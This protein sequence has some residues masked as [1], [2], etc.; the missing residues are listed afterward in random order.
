MCRQYLDLDITL[1]EE[2]V[3]RVTQTVLQHLNRSA[4]ELRRLFLIEDLIDSIKVSSLGQPLLQFFQRV[5]FTANIKSA[6]MH[7]FSSL[8]SFFVF[9]FC[10]M[11]Q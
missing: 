10:W 5:Y 2:K 8:R 1:K 11:S 3:S 6:A 9:V 7:V 4:L